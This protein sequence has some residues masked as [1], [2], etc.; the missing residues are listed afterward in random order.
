MK[1]M[2]NHFLESKDVKIKGND[3][4][5]LED[6]IYNI[7]SELAKK[8]QE[9]SFFISP[10]NGI[11]EYAGVGSFL[12]NN[13]KMLGNSIFSIIKMLEDKANFTKFIASLPLSE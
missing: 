6:F 4:K 2:P 3:V 1:E 11:L 13:Y 7:T 12:E 8:T 9:I 10:D 5:T